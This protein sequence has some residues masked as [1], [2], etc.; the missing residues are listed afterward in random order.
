MIII[1]LL[2]VTI[3]WSSG[4]RCRKNW[5]FVEEAGIPVGKKIKR[6]DA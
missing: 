1:N 5:G 2:N 6:I 3:H 4:I